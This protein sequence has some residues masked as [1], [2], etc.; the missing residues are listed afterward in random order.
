MKK[1]KK[2]GLNESGIGFKRKAEAPVL[3]KYNENPG[4]VGPG[5]SCPSINALTL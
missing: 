3:N 1:R 2:V 4:S 5:F